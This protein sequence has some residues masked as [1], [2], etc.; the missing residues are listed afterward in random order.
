M[1]WKRF[2]R[3][4]SGKILF[5]VCFWIFQVLFQEEVQGQ[6]CFIQL[7]PFIS[8]VKS[9]EDTCLILL[10]CPLRI[11]F[12]PSDTEEH[13]LWN[14]ILKI[15]SLHFSIR[16]V[17]VYLLSLICPC[18]YLWKRKSYDS[19]LLVCCKLQNWRNLSRLLWL[20]LHLVLLINHFIY[21]SLGETLLQID[22]SQV[23]HV[24]ELQGLIL[25]R[26]FWLCE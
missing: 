4:C 15:I 2:C 21:L 7:M 12:Q 9:C 22:S 23:L 8:V 3:E 24:W 20:V 26:C 19:Y 6:H 13:K 10:F 14:L 16:L 25:C 17:S 11:Y 18:F 1:F 5:S